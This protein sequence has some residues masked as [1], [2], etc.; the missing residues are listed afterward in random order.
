MRTP[1]P[2]GQ[3]SDIHGSRISL[4][5]VDAVCFMV[6]DVLL[7]TIKGEFC[8]RELDIMM[9]LRDRK[10][11]ALEKLPPLR[12]VRPPTYN[13]T[14]CY[15]F[16]SVWPPVST[17]FSPQ[18][19]NASTASSVAFRGRQGCLGSSTDPPQ[20]LW[21]GWYT[22]FGF[23]HQ[24]TGSFADLLVLITRRAPWK[25]PHATTPLEHQEPCPVKLEQSQGTNKQ[26][27]CESSWG[28]F[29]IRG[30]I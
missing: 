1:N 26:W 10:V 29:A 6:L 5:K 4:S 28:T 22:L 9:S 25:V 30:K 2:L 12:P 20:A 14:L 17:S 23:L 7:N 19:Q 21:D 8:F 3:I 13:H 18:G 16:A 24:Y 15:V 27:Y 11:S